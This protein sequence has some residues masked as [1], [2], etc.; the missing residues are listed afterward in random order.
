MFVSD[1]SK[2]DEKGQE[3]GKRRKPVFPKKPERLNS[4]TALLLG[5][6]SNY[7]PEANELAIYNQKIEPRQ[8]TQL[9]KLQEA[10]LKRLRK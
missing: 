3:M 5:K 1:E 6:N 10:M 8:A 4:K 9:T 2:Q 7:F